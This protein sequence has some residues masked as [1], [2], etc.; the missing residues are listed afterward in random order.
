M[1][2][3]TLDAVWIVLAL[4]GVVIAANVEPLPPYDFWWHLVMGRQIAL[5]D[6]PASNLFLYTIPADIPFHDQPWLAQWLMYH[7]HEIGGVTGGMALRTVLL[8]AAWAVLLRALVLRSSNR[9]GAGLA[10][11]AALVSYPVLTYRTRL[12]A[13]LPFVVLI[14]L[15]LDERR[16]RWV[17]AVLFVGSVW[18][19][20]VHGTFILAP[21]LVF[22]A[23]GAEFLQAVSERR[24]RGFLR[25]ELPWWSACLVAT[26]L[27]SLV[28]PH[29]IENLRYVIGLAVTS[30][31]SATVSEWLPPDLETGIGMAFALSLVLALAVLAK[32]RAHVR[33]VEAALLLATTYL[34]A[35]AVRSVFWF[36]ATAALVCAPHVLRMAQ[37]YVPERGEDEGN[38]LNV[39]IA[40]VMVF[41]AFVAQPG[42]LPA[43]TR[44]ELGAGRLLAEGEGA[45]VLSSE[46]APVAVV[47]ALEAAG[48]GKVFH[49]QALGGQL[50]WEAGPNAREVAFVDQ[51]MELIPESVWGA[52]FLT[53]SA[54][55]WGGTFEKH[56]VRA[57]LLSV[58][59]QW[60][61]IQALEESPDWELELV[62]Q[63]HLLF[64]RSTRSR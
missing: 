29:G 42:V 25:V 13:F 36:G 3:P 58:E 21:V 8:L 44:V 14:V 43:S 30:N 53:S 19:A 40:S 39:V 5:G 16:R 54:R 63:N 12:F 17:P 23:A 45:G 33:V 10:L 46:N 56:D 55:G 7:V 37:S 35:S 4:A 47:R 48:D 26:I 59:G 38:L 52:Y 15:L 62:G 64:V 51:R 6:F 24:L 11:A 57:A 28:S 9:I 34:A 49:D 50:E 22:G 32:E 18:W 60:P 27:G 61:L 31:V 20:N 41:V 2:L 1:R